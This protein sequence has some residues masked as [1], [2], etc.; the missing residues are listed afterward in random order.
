M[1]TNQDKRIQ[2]YVDDPKFHNLVKSIEA[3]FYHDTGVT[4]G[5]FLD[6]TYVARIRYEQMNPTLPMLFTSESLESMESFKRR[7]KL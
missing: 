7:F 5:D 4:Y 1:S 2:R 6:A 3:M